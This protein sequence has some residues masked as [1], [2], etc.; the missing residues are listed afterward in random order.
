[1]PTFVRGDLCEKSRRYPT[2]TLL[3]VSFPEP[4]LLLRVAFSLTASL[5]PDGGYE[6]T[7]HG[8]PPP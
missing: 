6:E 1:M 7:H 3:N 2:P 5:L 8:F 4:Q